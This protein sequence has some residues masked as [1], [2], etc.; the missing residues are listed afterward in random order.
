VLGLVGLHQRREDVQT[1]TLW[2]PST[3]L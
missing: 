3:K 2:V 1:I